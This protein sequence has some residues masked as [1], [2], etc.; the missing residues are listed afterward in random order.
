[1]SL[2]SIHRRNRIGSI[3]VELQFGF[4][5][6]L[7]ALA[8]PAV[9]KGEIPALASMFAALS[10]ALFLWTLLHNKLGN[11]NIRPIPKSS[12]QLVTSG[13]YR[14][15]RHPM[16]TSVLLGAASLALMSDPLPGWSAWT[17][18]AMVLWVKSII[19]ER[20]MRETHPGYGA[21]CRVSRRFV[22]WFF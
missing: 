1:M 11:F 8:A 20:W 19:E 17:A 2:P 5:L 12:G 15:I 7:L 9:L 18:L 13:P 16:Y 10:V 22:P 4:M 3:L 14:Q 21:Y 6:L